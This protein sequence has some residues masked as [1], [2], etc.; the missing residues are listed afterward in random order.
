MKLTEAVGYKAFLAEEYFDSRIDWKF[1][2]YLLDGLTKYEDT[3]IDCRILIL[4]YD[5]PFF[6]YNQDKGYI[7]MEE[8]NNVYI[9]N[10]SNNMIGYCSMYMNIKEKEQ[11]EK[12][13]L[14]YAVYLDEE[15]MSEY[16]KTIE[17][18][19]EITN[20]RF[21]GT[22]EATYYMLRPK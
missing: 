8:Y 4:T 2:N 20:I 22:I 18:K 12:N 10:Q 5:L 19:A 14:L 21:S 15:Y 6:N 17:R 13:G 16:L 11:Y 3:N 7:E 1:F 9:H